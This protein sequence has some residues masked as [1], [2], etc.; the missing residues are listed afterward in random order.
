MSVRDLDS[1]KGK[2]LLELLW[3]HFEV[4]VSILVLEEA[5][6]IKS[7]PVQQEHKLLLDLSD[8]ALV[9]VVWLLLTIER[10]SSSVIKRNIN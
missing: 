6:C 1:Q 4:V 7:L 9:V 8:V 2:S 3:R 10:L 5:L